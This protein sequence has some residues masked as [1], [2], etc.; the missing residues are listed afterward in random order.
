MTPAERHTEALATV[1]GIDIYAVGLLSDIK[2]KRVR[3]GLRSF[4]WDYAIKGRNWRAARN[5]FNGYLAE[6]Q[7]GGHNAG[8][9][10]TK[11]AALRRVIAIHDKSALDAI[12]EAGS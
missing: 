11:R 3:R 2:R 10:W 5:Y 1:L 8:R 6:C 12:T 4:L 7:H 9:G